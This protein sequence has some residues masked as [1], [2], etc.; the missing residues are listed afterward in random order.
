MVSF[1]LGILF[2]LRGSVLPKAAMLAFPS[3]G[4][5][6][7]LHFYFDWM[8]YTLEPIASGGPVWA[9]MTTAL[10]VLIVFRTNQ[11][12]SRY[13]EGATLLM[14][15]RG[16]WLNATSSLIAFCTPEPSM[17]ALAGKFQHQIVRMMSLLYCAA[18]EQVAEIDNDL[19]EVI[20]TTGLDQDSLAFLM[21]CDERCDVLLQWVRKLVVK[22]MSNGV[23]L[24]P[25]PILTRVFQELSRGVVSAKDVQKIA[26]FPFPFPYRQ[27]IV[28]MLSA[29]TALTPFMAIVMSGDLVWGAG[30]TFG[31]VL[32]LWGMNCV[33]IELEQPYLAQTRT[34]SPLPR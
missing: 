17:Q 10:A 7:A 18:L 27:P 26:E 16:E 2:R 5:A 15:V 29:Q 23:I 14:Q 8:G 1:E 9:L 31:S 6:V 12:Y 34:T 20:D 21:E 4:F 24:V 28:A 25:P 32:A 33:A 30:V 3:A 13:W 22:N 19:L 11:A